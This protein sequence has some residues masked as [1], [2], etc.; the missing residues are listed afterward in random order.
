MHT[1][2]GGPLLLAFCLLL[3][4]HTA[5]A[6]LVDLPPGLPPEAQAQVYAEE[7]ARLFKAGE[8]QRAVEHFERAHALRPAPANLRNIARSYEK[9]G[10]YGKA[11]A[12]Y[13]AHIKS[14]DTRARRDRSQADAARV[15][16]LIPGG[17]QV[18]C[19]NQG[20]EVELV[21]VIDPGRFPCPHTWPDLPQGTHQIRLTLRGASI[22]TTEVR[23]LPGQV[24]YHTLLP[25]E[26]PVEVPARGPVETP[27]PPAST[28][29]T[30]QRWLLGSGGAVLA[31]GAGLHAANLISFAELEDE[32]DNQRLR[33]AVNRERDLTYTAYGVGAALVTGA[34]VWWWLSEQADTEG[35]NDNP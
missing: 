31:V 10:D 19:P 35:G 33:N 24:T 32:P 16:A 3:S 15:A 2:G 13:Q 17:L 11:V 29:N 30:G 9:A 23:V 27:P 25:V 28:F 34:L 6:R 7:G 8:Y 1:L 12:W 26:T 4:A 22:H 14:G 5:I 20:G 21:G 18:N